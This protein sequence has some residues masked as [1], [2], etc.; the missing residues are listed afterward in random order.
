MITKF[1]ICYG[2]FLALRIG[3]CRA[4]E[5]DVGQVAQRENVHQKRRI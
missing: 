2:P 1:N 4:V 3:G 5:L